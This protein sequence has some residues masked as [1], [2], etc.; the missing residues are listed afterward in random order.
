[1]KIAIIGCGALGSYY[2]GKLHQASHQVHFILR[3]DFEHVKQHGVRISSPQ[4]DFKFH[5]RITQDSQTIGT[6][7]LVIISIKTTANSQ[8][9]ALLKPL[10]TN[11]TIVLCLQNGLGNTELISSYLP[12]DQVIGGLCFICVNR[13]APG[14]ISH[15]DHGQITIGEAQGWPEPRTHQLANRFQNAGI[16]C[17]VTDTLKKAQWEKLVWNIPFNGLG[18]AGCFGHDFFQSSRGPLPDQRSSPLSTEELLNDS[19]WLGTVSLLMHEIIEVANELGYALKHT[20]AGRMI[21]NTRSMKNYRPS[22]VIDFEL[23]RPLE[24]ESMFS[25]PLTEA[26]KTNVAIP[27]FKRVCQ[28]LRHIDKDS[29]PQNN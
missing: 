3:S 15:L 17:K 24:F 10:I 14:M 22:T 27:T 26:M 19:D 21:H 4:G 18:V 5:P 9:E 20:L 6:C 23:G 13:T 8:I 7:D 16:P 11:K 25:I 29:A 2:G 1:M 28:I 12:I